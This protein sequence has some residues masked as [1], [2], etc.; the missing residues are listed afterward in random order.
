[1]CSHDNFRT[2]SPLNQIFGTMFHLDP[3]WV[4]VGQGHRSKLK[5][6]GRRGKSISELETV[7]KSHHPQSGPCDLE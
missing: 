2:K 5:V 1:M 4:T 7:N 3:V 6:V